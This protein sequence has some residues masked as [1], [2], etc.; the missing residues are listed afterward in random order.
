MNQLKLTDKQLLDLL[1]NESNM[2]IKQW[3][4]K[5]RKKFNLDNPTLISNE[6]V[7]H[8]LTNPK[9]GE[10][11]FSQE[12]IYDTGNFL[13]KATEYGRVKDIMNKPKSVTQPKVVVK[14]S[15]KF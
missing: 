15:R 11:Y 2:T 14:K 6:R 8:Q 7:Q 12:L 9:T 3:E 13:V 1:L 5:C 10:S 4:S